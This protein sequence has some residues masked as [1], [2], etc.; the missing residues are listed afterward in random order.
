MSLALYALC[1]QLI[2]LGIELEGYVALFLVGHHQIQVLA[3]S[4]ADESGLAR[5]ESQ[6]VH[7]NVAVW[8][9][10]FTT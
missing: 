9:M 7:E 4:A 2:V 10:D 3:K 1:V 5:I 8:M 6:N